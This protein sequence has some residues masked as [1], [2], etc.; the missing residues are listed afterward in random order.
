MTDSF[1]HRFWV[2]ESTDLFLVTSPAA[3]ESVRALLAR[4]A[5]WRS[6]PRPSARSS[7][8]APSQ[9]G[10]PRA[11][12]CAPRRHAVYCSCRGPGDWGRSTP[13][14]PRLARGR[15]L[16]FSPWPERTPSYDAPAPGAGGSAYT[17]GG[18]VWLHRPDVPELM[19]ASDV[20]V[21]SSGDTCREARTLGRGIMLLRRRSRPRAGE[22]DAR[23]GAGRGNRVHADA[24]VDCP[25]RAGSFVGRPRPLSRWRRR[26]PAEVAPAQFVAA[27]Q[28]LGLKF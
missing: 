6:S 28:G 14:P 24:G 22:P 10:G 18:A 1:A 26:P 11:P 21:T 4:G 3:G 16:G 5:S 25:R 2:H 8:A 20:V 15:K 13:L 9:R 17:R 27:L 7:T 23:A 19:A 12:R